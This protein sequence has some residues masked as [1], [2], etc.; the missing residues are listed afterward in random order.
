MAVRRYADRISA[1]IRDRIDI[2]Q[3]FRPMRKAYLQAALGGGEASA[4]VAD[5]VAEARARQ[6]RRLVGTPW[7]VNG[8]V[9]GP[10]LR[11]S[12]P[13]PEDVSLVDAAFH[14]GRLSARG[15]DKVLRVAWTV[16]DLA[17]RDRPS[18]EDVAVALAMRSGEPASALTRRAG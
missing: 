4:A 12:L 9:A 18:A 11:E 7:R 10:Y 15:V 16:A 1:P 17:G 6:V 14:H 5:R 3:S 2:H 13:L 8:E